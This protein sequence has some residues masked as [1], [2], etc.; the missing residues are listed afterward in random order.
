VDVLAEGID[1]GMD[2]LCALSSESAASA[3]T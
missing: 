3:T 2:E 1:H